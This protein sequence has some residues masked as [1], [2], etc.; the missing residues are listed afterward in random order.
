V[1]EGAPES[2]EPIRRRVVAYVHGPWRVTYRRCTESGRQTDIQRGLV[3]GPLVY[4]PST[5]TVWVA[6]I[7]DGGTQ[8]IMIRRDAITS[9][10]SPGHT[11]AAPARL[12]QTTRNDSKAN[13]GE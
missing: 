10:T 1:D 12:T 5:A 6:V 2:V 4:D 7:P 11:S 13:A 8:H 3:V 9:I